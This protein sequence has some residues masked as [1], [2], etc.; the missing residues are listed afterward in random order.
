[1]GIRVNKFSPKKGSCKNCGMFGH[2]KVTVSKSL[3][4]RLPGR[5]KLALEG[6]DLLHEEEE[7]MATKV[8]ALAVS[9]HMLQRQ[10]KGCYRQ[11]G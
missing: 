4:T 2:G 8:I 5:L 10:I 1:M 7:V 6:V 9:R 3:A 11:L